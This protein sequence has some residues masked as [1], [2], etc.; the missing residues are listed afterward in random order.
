MSVERSRTFEHNMGMLIRLLCAIALVAVA[1]DTARAQNRTCKSVQWG[2]DSFTIEERGEVWTYSVRA[3]GP[4]WRHVHYGRHGFGLVCAGC[5]FS[6]P[7][8]ELPGGLYDFPGGLYGLA[9]HSAGLPPT[10]AE[11]A[12]R[13][14]EFIGYP[15]TWLGPNHLEHSGFREDVVLGPFTG[16]AVLFRTVRGENSQ[17]S[18]ADII[19]ARSEGVLAIE[20]TDGCVRFGA[21]SLV[22][23][24]GRPDLWTPLNSFLKEITIDRTRGR[25]K[26]PAPKCS[27]RA[28]FE[29]KQSDWSSCFARP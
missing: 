21:V 7:G 8:A 2:V 15:Y 17:K 1:H 13:R 25:P 20:L 29:E 5:A 24:S 9:I 10:A 22:D 4:F 27:L 14:K 28:I 26:S 23:W 6:P 12:E 19:A 16:Y 18:T 3:S 11:R